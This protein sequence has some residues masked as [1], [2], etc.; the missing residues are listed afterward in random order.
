MAPEIEE[1]TVILEQV[2]LDEI[3][4]TGLAFLGSNAWN[5]GA[6][7]PYS[8]FGVPNTQDALLEL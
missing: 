8:A 2:A 3:I 7:W 5:V 1:E 6:G 4:L